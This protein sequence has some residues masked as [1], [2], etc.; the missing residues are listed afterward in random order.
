MFFPDEGLSTRKQSMY[1][2][3]LLTNISIVPDNHCRVWVI[4]IVEDPSVTVKCR[5]P[6]KALILYFNAVIL[7]TNISIVPDICIQFTVKLVQ[8]HT[9][10]FWHPV[11]SNKNLWSPSIF[12]NTLF[13]KTLCILKPVTDSNGIPSCTSAGCVKFHKNSISSLV[14]VALTRY[15]TPLFVKV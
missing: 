1:A 7:L 9:W 5:T 14:G 11:T 6:I 2:V 10:V 4:L 8:S 12:F 13:L 3:I 15:M